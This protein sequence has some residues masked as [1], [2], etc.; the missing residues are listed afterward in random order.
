MSYLKKFRNLNVS[1][2][3]ISPTSNDNSGLN[4][5]YVVVGA[6][7][8]PETSESKREDMDRKYRLTAEG[9]EYLTNYYSLVDLEELEKRGY[10]KDQY[11]YNFMTSIQN[12]DFKKSV[13]NR[14]IRI[15]K[16]SINQCIP[17]EDEQGN[18]YFPVFKLGKNIIYTDNSKLMRIWNKEENRFDIHFEYG[19]RS[20]EGILT[21]KGNAHVIGCTIKGDTIYVYNPKLLK[22]GTHYFH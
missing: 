21:S 14:S 4:L 12:F 19:S 15:A 3:L 22:R 8:G 13:P 18:K 10:I 2:E 7:T 5:R 9:I 1:N 16:L 11:P 17:K 20:V 6:N